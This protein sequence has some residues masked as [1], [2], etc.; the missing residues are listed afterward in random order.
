M[1]TRIIISGAILASVMVLLQVAQY[2]LLV[3]DHS[4]E[5]YGG[6]VAIIFA[7]TGIV[8]GR[9]LAGNKEVVIEKLVYL[10]APAVYKEPFETNTK[11]LEK[12]N[13]SRREQEILA[14]MAQGLSNQEIA[15]R[16]Y[17]SIHTVKTHA[18]NLFVKLDVQRRTQAVKRAKELNLIP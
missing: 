18:S 17:L 13:I 2:K 7:V 16:A 15:D 14:L 6:T 10:P 3:I 4:P 1:R 9:K 8:I 5:L 12:L 11:K